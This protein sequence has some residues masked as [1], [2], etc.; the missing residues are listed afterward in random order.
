MLISDEDSPSSPGQTSSF[1]GPFGVA[2]DTEHS[3]NSEGSHETGD[4]G[5]FSHESN[6]EIH[7]SSV[8]STTPLAS[9]C[10]TGSDSG[11]EP[12][13][14]KCQ[15]PAVSSDAEQT[16]SAVLQPQ[17]VLSFEKNDFPI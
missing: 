15:D 14:R 1:P 8:I 16:S 4:S 12:S 10:F 17:P 3:A 5:R 9:D 6:D 11:G 13:V 2:A 7:L